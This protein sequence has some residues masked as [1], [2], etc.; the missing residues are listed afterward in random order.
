MQTLFGSTEPANNNPV[1]L[2]K[3]M[4]NVIQRDIWMEVR[5]EASVTFAPGIT[6]NEGHGTELAIL[7]REKLPGIVCWGSA[8]WT[9]D[10]ACSSTSASSSTTMA[11]LM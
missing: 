10:I 11:S 1:R 5:L 8:G 7:Y 2:V 6:T 3:F 9:S 4:Q